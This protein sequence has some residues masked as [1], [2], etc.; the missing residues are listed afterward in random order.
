MFCTKKVAE[1]RE[2]DENQEEKNCAIF[3]YLN[4]L[5]TQQVV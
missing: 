1:N 4:D 2:K 3:I 5:K